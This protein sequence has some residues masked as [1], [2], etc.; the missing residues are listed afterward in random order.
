MKS[1][2]I[3]KSNMLFK[4]A[5]K[6]MTRNKRLFGPYLF[7]GGF[8]VFA[9]F[10]MASIVFNALVM[11]LPHSQYAMAMMEIGLFLLG[12]IMVP[13]IGY[14]HGFLIKQRYKEMALYSVLGLEKVH[15]ALM[16]IYES[17]MVY[18]TVII[19]GCVSGLL[20]GK[21]LF[22]VMMRLSGLDVHASFDLSVKP[23]YITV[24]FFAVLYGMTLVKSIWEV[25]RSGPLKMMEKQRQI[26]KKP[27]FAVVRGL[28]GI[29]LLAWGYQIAITMTVNSEIF[30]SFFLAV[31][32]VIIGTYMTFRSGLHLLMQLLKKKKSFYYNANRF[33]P[34]SGIHQ[35]INHSSASLSNLCIFSTMVIITMMCTLSLFSGR[36][37]ITSYMYP[38]DM[39]WFVS[40]DDGMEKAKAFESI[41][42]EETKR[43]DVPYR[44][45]IMNYTSFI[46][47]IDGTKVYLEGE[48]PKHWIYITTLEAFA[49]VEQSLGRDPELKSLDTG[50][51][52]YMYSTGEVYG[53]DFIEISNHTY[54]TSDI[55]QS[56]GFEPRSSLNGLSIDYFIIA[57]NQQVYDN[58]M[59]GMEGFATKEDLQQRRGYY[60]NF[61]PEVGTEQA[62]ALVEAIKTE[63]D[64]RDLLAT[65]RNGLTGYED[66]TAMTGG[67]LFLGMFC[68]A[69][70]MVCFVI[71]MYYKQISEGYDDRNQFIILQKVGLSDKEVRNTIL[72]QIMV[73]FFLPLLL[74][75]LHALAAMGMITKL[76][77]TLSLYDAQLVLQSGLIVSGIY[78][79]IYAI[80]Y[81]LTGRV[82]YRI[83]RRS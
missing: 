30:L 76:F 73:V 51:D 70:F 18:A 71:I 6:S 35:R 28:I 78:I 25:Y 62:Q 36:D 5:L 74:A 29:L 43:Q 55:N 39:E 41:V 69:I 50:A 22:M 3:G 33:I 72:R 77:A 46:A 42:E 7:A 21:L 48:G 10:V 14:T 53:Y 57:K 83:V 81:S 67:L 12:I 59:M 61:E 47:R 56:M 40:R 45:G 1:A 34:I 37:I 11:T 54:K 17:L 31:L 82:Y 79:I 9:F 58:L 64:K 60:M 38:N 44:M 8:A 68:C 26:D 65:S 32:L 63:A 52:V 23:L 75:C 15:I 27:K 66:V 20:M 16:F 80:S 19:S 49:G 4:L 13:F 2:R 24:I